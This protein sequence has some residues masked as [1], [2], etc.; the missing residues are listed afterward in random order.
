MNND[1]ESWQVRPFLTRFSVI[2]LRR[3]WDSVTLALQ[4]W[5]TRH[6]H[7][8]PCQKHF[9]KQVCAS[10]IT[11]DDSKLQIHCRAGISNFPSFPWS[12]SRLSQELSHLPYTLCILTTRLCSNLGW[13]FLGQLS[14]VECPRGRAPW[15]PW[16]HRCCH[17]HRDLQHLEVLLFPK[18]PTH[19]IASGRSHVGTGALMKCQVF[20]STLGKG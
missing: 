8:L 18:I 12:L 20:C 17:R 2:S 15:A 5:D 19:C 6:W 7:I 16:P 4:P 11:Q 14:L 3:W 13:C 9:L 10:N 1:F